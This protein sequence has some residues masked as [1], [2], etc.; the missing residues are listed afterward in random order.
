M[1]VHPDFDPV[2]IHLGPLSVRWYGITYLLGFWGFWFLS[3]IRGRW[4]FNNWTSEQVSDVLFY[5]VLGVILGG[6]IGYTFFYNVD[7]SGRLIFLHDPLVI[8]R[9]WEGGMS[10]H[11]G[12]IGVI[13]ALAV[14]ARHRKIS[15]WQVADFIAVTAPIGL[16][17]GRIGNFINGELWGA[18]TTLPWGMVFQQA[19]DR[20]PR[21]P[22]ML[23]EAALEGLVTLAIL[24]WFGRKPRPKMA[25]SGLFLILYGTFRF[26][27]EFVREPDRQLGYLY[28]SGWFTMGMQLCIPMLLAG[29]TLMALAYRRNTSA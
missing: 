6:R 2:A 8:F 14:Y 18:K 3:T 27:V 4:A 9:I 5:G 24:W 23:Y 15:F 28:N 26:L 20:M 29:M 22:S 19:P 21:H 12:L 25:T 7:D 11:G 13:V 10:F 17:A 16:F 1:L